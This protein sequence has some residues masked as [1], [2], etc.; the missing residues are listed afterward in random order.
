[1]RTAGRDDVLPLAFPIVTKDGETLTELP[2]QKGQSI[3]VSVCAYNRLPSVWGSDAEEWNPG[4][5]LDVSQE[6]Q[7]FVGVYANL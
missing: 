2:I 5:F 3:L 4:R 1:M 7:T 6:K